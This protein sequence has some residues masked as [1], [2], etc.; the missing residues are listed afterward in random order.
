MT[1]PIEI[2]DARHPHQLMHLTRDWGDWQ[3]VSLYLDRCQVDTPNSLVE[4]T[5]AHVARLRPNVGKV[6]DFGA[7]DGRFSRYGTYRE[8][9]GYE[10]D[11]NRYHNAELPA[12]AHLRYRCAFSENITDA[13]LCIGNP[14]FV[15]NQDL[16]SGW[17]QQASSILYDRTGVTVSGLS[18]AWQYFFLL[19]LA[20]L[21]D[22]GLSA[23]ILPYEWVS[24]PSAKPLREYIS[25]NRW[26]VHVYRLL[27]STFRRVLTTSS[28]TIID[29]EAREGTWNYFEER[30]SEAYAPLKSP[31]GT[32][33]VIEYTSQSAI[34][35]TAPRAV[36]GLSPGTQKALTLNEGDRVHFGLRVR[37][38]VVPCITTLRP[39]P[40]AETELTNKAFRANYVDAGKKCW[41]IRA[42]AK[43]SDAL[44]DYLDSVPP[45]VYHTTT[46]LG[47]AEWW[48]FRVPP[49]PR[50]LVAM[51]FIG[52][53]P[54]T[55][56]NTIGA[57]PVGGVYGVLNTSREIAPD[58]IKCLAKNDLTHRVVAHSQGLRKIEVSQLNTLLIDALSCLKQPAAT[59]PN[60]RASH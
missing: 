37:R 2:S 31:S 49:I 55:V 48:R 26:T 51:S 60:E 46:C 12:N 52:T 47:R 54:K 6:V 34:G 33:D 10:I 29:K 43:A 41:L 39:L 28:L 8:Y 58:L 22:D 15:R 30:T 17:R 19:S 53:F 36:R 1:S 9:I 44:R 25:T 38:D 45:H 40:S 59:P 32:A 50:V 56:I 57:R 14:P 27:D 42:D 13:D 35:N 11:R 18:N 16:P 24:R 7:G 21:R 4:S 3:D 20:S 5:W 23:L